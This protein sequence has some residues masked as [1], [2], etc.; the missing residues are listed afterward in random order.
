MQH[1]DLPRSER[2]VQIRVYWRQLAV[3]HLIVRYFPVGLGLNV[4]RAPVGRSCQRSTYEGKPRLKENLQRLVQL[5]EATDQSERASEW[6]Q[7][8]ADYKQRPEE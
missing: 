1:V 5:Y 4:V 8:L 3:T 6:K 2:M 7:K